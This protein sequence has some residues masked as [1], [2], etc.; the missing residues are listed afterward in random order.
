MLKKSHLRDIQNNYYQLAM[1]RSAM[2]CMVIASCLIDELI[3]LLGSIFKFLVLSLPNFPFFI[4][5]SVQPNCKLK[6]EG[7]RRNLVA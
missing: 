4:S 2:W 1:V 6:I 7:Q 5:I 3:F